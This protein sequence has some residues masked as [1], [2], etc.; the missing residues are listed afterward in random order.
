MKKFLLSLYISQ[1]G[2]RIKLTFKRLIGENMYTLFNILHAHG[3]LQKEI[4][5]QK[6]LLVPKA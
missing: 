6:E 4:E 1:S 2:L 3:S 5:G